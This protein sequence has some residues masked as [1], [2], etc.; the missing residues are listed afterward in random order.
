MVNLESP[1]FKFS[2]KI[3]LIIGLGIRYRIM[4]GISIFICEKFSSFKTSESVLN[5]PG[6]SPSS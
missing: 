6:L 1:T 2:E 4:G 3:G 5:S